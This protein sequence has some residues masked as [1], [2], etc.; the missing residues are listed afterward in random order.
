MRSA[1]PSRSVPVLA[2]TGFLGAG[3]TTVLN[4]VL[5]APG[6]RFGVVVNDFGTIDVD[7]AL[8]SGQ[9]DEAASIAGGCLCCLPEAGGLDEAL[10][11]LSRPRLRL[12]AILVEASGVAEP[13]ALAR[14]L[15]HSP[16]GGIRPG[17]L[18]DV[19]DALAYFETVDAPTPGGRLAA[20]PPLRF[21]AASL[22]VITKTALLPAAQR[23]ERIAAITERIHRRNPA[24]AVIEAPHGVIDPEL[25]VDVASREHPQ[26]ELPIAEITRQARGEHEHQHAEQVSVTA[27]GA[28]DPGRIADLL[29][30][31]P[32]GAYR[33]KGTVTTA[34]PRGPEHYAVNLA[35]RHVH[36]ARCP[37]APQDGLVAIGLPLDPEVVRRRLL[38][39]LAPA[40]DGPGTA[41]SRGRARLRRHL[42]R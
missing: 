21:A 37:A 8:L 36:L 3:K 16:V 2:L 14:L 27:D 30:D 6:A 32:P 12:D 1:P 5:R 15:E 28:V 18:V 26:G 13:L 4:S 42:H 17:G 9:V 39:A 20:E 24:V 34:G 40:A 7:A 19:V 10:A 41:P 22:V 38:E 35:G 31:P 23:E 25:V 33:L 29:E 11:Q